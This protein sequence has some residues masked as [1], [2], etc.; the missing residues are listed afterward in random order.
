MDNFMKYIKN[1][2]SF[3]TLAAPLFFVAPANGAADYGSICFDCHPDLQSEIQK[4]EA[5]T[6]VKKGNCNSCHNPHASR[7]K[8]LLNEA[9]EEI[10]FSCHKNDTVYDYD[11]LIIHNPVKIGNCLACHDPHSSTNGKLLVKKKAEI[12]FF[13]HSRESIIFGKESHPLVK[14]GECVECHDPHSSNNEGLLKRASKDLCSKCHKVEEGQFVV[15]HM[16]Y[17]M[18]KSNC[19]S[20]HNTH[21]SNTKSLLK[22][23]IHLPVAKKECAVC[24]NAANSKNALT[25]KNAGTE[26]CYKCHQETK[27][28]FQKVNNHQLGNIKNSCLNCHNPHASNGKYL[29]EGKEET[30]CFKCHFDTKKRMK[31]KT[32]KTRHPDIE[33]CSACH[34]A[35][36]SD[37]ALFLIANE[38]ESC[39]SGKCHQTQ[40]S[41]THPV[42]PGILDPRNKKEMSCLT[43]HDPMGTG[44]NYNLRLDPNKELCELC[45]N[46]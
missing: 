29:L 45:H 24:H 1:L 3:L 20:C 15:A 32:V 2:I 14:K 34:Q 23:S 21:S 43:C 12:C 16:G 44:Y 27:K 28:D 4:G 26:L 39:S 10:C 36:G 6:P 46:L 13:C 35:H 33:N 5:H 25:L 18:E 30:T 31:A 42:G 9:Q 41:F 38:G 19:S 17:S 37:N 8:G 40:A 22:A 11:R 7:H